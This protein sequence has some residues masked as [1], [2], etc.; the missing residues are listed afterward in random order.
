MP[1]VFVWE[2][3][4][5]GMKRAIVHGVGAAALCVAA[6]GAHAQMTLTARPSM[7][8]AGSATDQ[9]GEAFTITG[10]SGITHRS[11]TAQGSEFLAVMDNSSR[12][13]RIA[14]AF[15]ANGS[16]ASRSVIGG[17]TLAQAGD[18]EGITFTTSAQNWVYI[19]DETGPAIRAFSLTSGDVMATLTVPEVF[20][21]P[22]NLRG[23]FGFESLTRRAGTGELWTAN[24]EAL[25]VDG[26]LSTPSAGTLVRLTRY[27]A[28]GVPRQQ[29]AYRTEPMHGSAV[30][31][32]RSGVSDLVAL[33]D[34]RLLVLERSF[35]LG[36]GFFR[37]AVYLVDP[38]QAGVTDVSGLPG[39][40]G[41]TLTVVSKTELWAAAVGQ[42][43]EGLALGPRLSMQSRV[44]LGVVDDADVLSNNTLMPFQLT[45]A[46][47]CP[48]DADGSG[49]VTIDDLF[50][51]LNMWFMGADAADI[52]GVGGVGI[53]DLFGFLGRWFAGY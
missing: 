14:A 39:L 46:G 40:I 19:S 10:M 17:M 29:I 24:E 25:T 27:D 44:V 3:W 50:V 38:A 45:D 48:A 18:Y 13:V 7:T 26:P 20:T 31:G 32:A 33:P 5:N 53:D 36:Q 52:D 41:Q 35:S 43:L 16:I 1:S 12:V 4:V 42:N 51:Y 22:G 21:T 28:L 47:A 6:A 34:G 15:N 30:S 2:V 23:N 49:G 37:G 9:H 8:I 11:G